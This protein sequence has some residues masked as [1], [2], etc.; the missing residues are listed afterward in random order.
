VNTIDSRGGEE[1]R[2][3]ASDQRCERPLSPR[4]KRAKKRKD[5]RKSER[6]R[7]CLVGNKRNFGDY[8][9]NFC[10]SKVNKGPSAE[11]G[12]D[13]GKDKKRCLFV[14]A[15]SLGVLKILWKDLGREFMG[16][17]ELKVIKLR[18]SFL[19][20]KGKKHYSTIRRK[21]NLKNRKSKK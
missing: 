4:R 11:G 15:T 12:G 9:L 1:N 13:S 18:Q 5:E 20:V 14:P 7:P 10:I 21:P 17:E 6:E 2:W 16:Y 8:G 3:R 19:P